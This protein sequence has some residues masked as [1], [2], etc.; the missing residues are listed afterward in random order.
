MTV[1][2]SVQE[3]SALVRAFDRATRPPVLTFFS[4]LLATLIGVVVVNHLVTRVDPSVSAEDSVT[5]DFP[6]F[7]TGARLI[8][9][10]R[11][12]A[13]YDL[14]AQVA[15]QRSLFEGG[16]A[17]WQPYLN[18]PALAIGLAPT[19]RLGYVPSFLI[20][21][22]SQF[23]FLLGSLLYLL[24]ATPNLG[25]SRRSGL[26]AILLSLS[27]L[28]V[29]LTTFG[30]QNTGFTLGLFSGIY[31]AVR[32]RHWA[33]A[34][35]FLGM[36]T[37][38]P[39]FALLL[40][41][42]MLIGRRYKV[43]G[44]ASAIGILHYAVAAPICGIDWPADLLRALST[45]TPLEMAEIGQR[46]FS[47]PTV[48]GQFLPSW[49]TVWVVLIAGTAVFVMLWGIGRRIPDNSPGYPAY[50]GMGICAVLFLSPHLLYYEAGL[51]VLPALLGI[52]TILSVE[53]RPSIGLRFFLTVGYLAYPMWEVAE[54]IQ[55]QPL[56]LLL[57]GF[58][59]WMARLTYDKS[60]STGE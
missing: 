60:K 37:Y 9:D 44:I 15:I 22:V 12:S 33:V 21:T 2:G 10:G 17:F 35:L 53:R 20:F 16:R 57:L 59:Y 41:I 25:C 29:T 42:V 23:F 19:T 36:L 47:L 6:A 52:E 46:H 18:P 56:F 26:T 5:G 8:S 1:S 39:Q 51:L 28:P 31:A 30:G 45:H 3:R 40:G 50:F 14:S 43:L 32:H 24:T 11:G 4:I 7:F 13:L 38:K 27:V 54:S 58:F 49:A 34:G 55:F 48:A